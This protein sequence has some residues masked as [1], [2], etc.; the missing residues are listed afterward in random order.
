MISEE[1]QNKIWELRQQG[2]SIPSISTELQL[3]KATVH[4]WCKKFDP[5]NNHNLTYTGL[6]KIKDEV[7]EYYKLT[8]YKET[9]SKYSQYN[10]KSIRGL[11]ITSGV[12]LGVYNKN[13]TPK[14]LSRRKSLNVINWKKNNKIKL[15]EYKGG[16]CQVCGYDRCENALEFH[17]IDPSLK[18]F[19]IS[20]NSFSFEKMKTEVDKCALLCSNCHREVHAKIINLNKFLSS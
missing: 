7:I 3:S 11:L 15:I 12:Y 20:N 5:D 10:K 9:C 18:S 13:E 17:H 14:E 6:Y 16:K 4:G 1:K 2:F 8:S 19:E